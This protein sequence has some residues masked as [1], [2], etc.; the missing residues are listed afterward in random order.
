MTT[1]IEE[2][3]ARQLLATLNKHHHELVVESIKGSWVGDG[4]VRVLHIKHSAGKFA[5]LPVPQKRLNADEISEFLY[6]SACSM[7]MLTPV[8]EALQENCQ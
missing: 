3:F 5:Q 6:K 1:H 2:Y 4:S 8:P 7:L